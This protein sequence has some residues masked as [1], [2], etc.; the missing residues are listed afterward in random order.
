MA[1]VIKDA[2]RTE[3]YNPKLRKLLFPNS[4]KNK[5]VAA[6]IVPKKVNPKKTYLN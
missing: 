6:F 5:L 1:Y 3:A 2:K 4:G